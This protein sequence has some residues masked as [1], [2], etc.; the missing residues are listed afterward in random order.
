VN[1]THINKRILWATEDLPNSTE[2]TSTCIS[3]P[4][5]TCETPHR[6]SSPVFRQNP[7]GWGWC[8]FGSESLRTASNL[9]QTSR[10]QPYRWWLSH[11][12]EC[13]PRSRSPI[14]FLLP[15]PA[16]SLS[17]LKLILA[18]NHQPCRL[19]GPFGVS[20]DSGRH[21]TASTL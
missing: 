4:E 6:R 15:R 5:H 8:P 7:T 17:Y 18:I 1:A 12:P 16:D 9:F 21:Q 11:C 20:H 10:F 13:R 19:L 2:T 3:E 14:H